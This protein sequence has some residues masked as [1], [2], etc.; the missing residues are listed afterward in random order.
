M[1]SSLKQRECAT[2]T[3]IKGS[4]RNHYGELIVDF[5]NAIRIAYPN[6][7]FEYS[8]PGCHG[9]SPDIR[10][11]QRDNR[12]ILQLPYG[13]YVSN[14]HFHTCG[15]GLLAVENARD[16]KLNLAGKPL[17]LL[18]GRAYNGDYRSLT[19]SYYLFGQNEDQ[20]F[21]LHRIRP[22]VGEQGDLNLCR[23]WIWQLKDGEKIL[24]RQGDLA[25]IRQ[26]KE[27]L[28][29]PLDA[30]RIS[31]GNHVVTAHSWRKSKGGRLFAFN[32][33]A[34][35]GEHQIVTVEGWVEMR[36]ARAWRSRSAD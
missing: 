9:G 18:T 3:E 26:K 1:V 34:H 23:K 19:K 28:G 15:Y 11:L 35:H 36:L 24:A 29:I 25:F 12:W 7:D 22:S 6:L 32:P 21:F 4:P 8:S 16:C 33:I 10:L 13:K 27:P 17:Y 5:E 2:V 20:S 14:K 30:S 31:F